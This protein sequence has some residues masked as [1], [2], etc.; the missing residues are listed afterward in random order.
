MKKWEAALLIGVLCTFLFTS[1][2]QTAETVTDLQQHVLRMHILANS[3]SEEDQELKYQVRDALLAEAESLFGT[4]APESREE[5]KATAAAHLSDM[6]TIAKR[7][8]Q[9]NG[10]SYPVQAELVT[11]DFTE[12][13]YEDLTMPAGTYEAIRITIGEAAGKNWWCVMYPP[14]CIPVAEEVAVEDA[15][16]EA[17]FTKEEQDVLYHPERYRV[18]LKLVE[19]VRHW[20]KK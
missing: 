2:F 16:A 10:Y 9:E 18:K 14:L 3:D 6:E 5:L 15:K 8:I 11:M 4:D 7:V 20:M 13:T 19:W 12:R 1:F 17:Y